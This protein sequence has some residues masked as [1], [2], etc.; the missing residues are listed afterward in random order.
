MPLGGPSIRGVG[1]VLIDG[2]LRD[3]STVTDSKDGEVGLTS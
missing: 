2:Y 3:L 1:L